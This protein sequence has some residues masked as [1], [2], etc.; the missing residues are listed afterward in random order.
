MTDKDRQVITGCE[1]RF[2][3][4]FKRALRMRRRKPAF[5]QILAR[6]RLRSG[7]RKAER[8]ARS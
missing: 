4:P 6:L 7:E 2:G 1:L 5:P 8:E 3:P